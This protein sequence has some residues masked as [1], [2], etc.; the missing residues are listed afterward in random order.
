VTNADSRELNHGI[1]MGLWTGWVCLVLLYGV[2]A[3]TTEFRARLSFLLPV[4]GETFGLTLLVSLV[5]VGAVALGITRTWSARSIGG[6]VI[7]SLGMVLLSTAVSEWRAIPQLPSV[8]S[9]WM[10][11]AAATVLG[12][13]GLVWESRRYRAYRLGRGGVPSDGEDASG[14]GRV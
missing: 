6:V 10:V 11:A 7:T 5:A 14:V 1:R 9:R 3:P 8:A 13:C 4:N 12:V 2:A